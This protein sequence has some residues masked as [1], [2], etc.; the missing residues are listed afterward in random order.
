MLVLAHYSRVRKVRVIE[1]VSDFLMEQITT[2]LLSTDTIYFGK[3][4]AGIGWGIE[5]LIQ[6]SYMKGCGVDILAEIDKRIMSVDIRRLENDSLEFGFMGLLHYVIIHVQGAAKSGKD[7]FDQTYLEDV[8][9]T[10]QSRI[11]AHPEDAVWMNLYSK[12]KDAEKGKNSYICD[13]SQFI[14]PISKTP[15]NVLGLRRGLAGHIEMKLIK[16][17]SENV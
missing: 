6:N 11:N 7:A 13:L 4:L 1:N 12:L 14:L 10:L 3:G 8:E 17:E 16:E 5:Y 15:L 2:R 9:N